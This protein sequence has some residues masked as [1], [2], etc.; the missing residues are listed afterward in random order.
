MCALL[1]MDFEIPHR[2]T[3]EKIT[4]QDSQCVGIVGPNGAGKTTFLNSLIG[5]SKNRWDFDM[6]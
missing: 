2:L 1:Y 5:S 6:E 4:L 3:V